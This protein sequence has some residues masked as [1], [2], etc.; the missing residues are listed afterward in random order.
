VRALDNTCCVVASNMGTYYLLP[1]SQLEEPLTHTPP[2]AARRVTVGSPKGLY[3]RARPSRALSG[4]ITGSVES[5]AAGPRRGPR[6]WG[7]PPP[8]PSHTRN[9]YQE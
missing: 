6:G 9:P 3:P 8:L 4:M 2:A 7:A 5:A 1:D